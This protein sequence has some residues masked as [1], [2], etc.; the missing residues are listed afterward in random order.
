[1]SDT[2]ID[3]EV[4]QDK[5]RRGIW[6]GLLSMLL[7]IGLITLVA[8]RIFQEDWTLSIH[9]V[10]W[11]KLILG[12]IFM[13]GTMGILGLRWRILLPETK[14][15]RSFFAAALSSG[16]L[17]NYALPGPMGE[18]MGAWLLQKED[19][20]PLS[21]G[22]TSSMLARLIGLL[23]AA[24]GTVCLWPFVT[25]KI[26]QAELILQILILGIGMGG[27]VLIVL[28]NAADR[29]YEWSLQKD[30]THPI[31][32][33][34]AAFLSITKLSWSRIAQAFVY[35]ALGHT[36]AFIGVW[37]SL[38]AL[39]SDPTAI[40]IA[41]AYLVGTCCGTV[42]FLF[43]GSQFTWDAIFIGLLTSTAG[44]NLAQATGGV[45]VLR[46]EQIAMMLFGALPLV[47]LLWK[48]KNR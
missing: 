47:W 24:I 10:H 17:I 34:S 4:V 8:H 2:P 23:T 14:A 37:F 30:D 5:V 35:S 1:M 42:A 45:A 28:F 41:F 39:G 13:V 6:K 25:V 44:Y 32:Q 22:L 36:T 33:V 16:L 38:Q 20:T 3:I 11:P 40:D 48:Q 21:T 26:E 19:K 18:V 27:L 29:F 7:I 15:S 9:T 31:R 46:I 43:P 12:W